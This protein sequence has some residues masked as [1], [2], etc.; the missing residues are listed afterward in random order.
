M[1]NK[2]MSVLNEEELESVDGGFGICA[3]LLAIVVS[4]AAGGA[5]GYGL[6]QIPQ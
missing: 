2:N 4:C 1:D 5:V 6:T 3:V